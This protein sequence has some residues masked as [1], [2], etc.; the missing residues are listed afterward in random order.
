[1][2]GSDQPSLTHA[3]WLQLS[4]TYT[5]LALN[6]VPGAVPGARK[7]GRGAYKTAEYVY[8]LYC[9]HVRT[10]TIY[11]WWMQHIST[12]THTHTHTHTVILSHESGVSLKLLEE[13]VVL[14]SL[15]VVAK[16]TRE[17]RSPH[18]TP[19]EL[20]WQ[21]TREHGLQVVRERETVSSLYKRGRWRK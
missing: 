3:N 4:I 18:V 15:G 7:Q 19:H 14:A 21:N 8:T 13:S 12:H 11:Q 5:A 10:C 9:E 20:T 6:A 2:C 1:M 16:P 17:L